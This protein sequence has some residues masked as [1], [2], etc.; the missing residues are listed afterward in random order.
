VTGSGIVTP[1]GAYSDH[2]REAPK[3]ADRR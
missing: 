3:E 1:T 2:G